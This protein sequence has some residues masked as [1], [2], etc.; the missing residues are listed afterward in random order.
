VEHDALILALR[1]VRR[2]RGLSQRDVGVLMGRR[3]YAN[4]HDWE[5]GRTVPT[6]V[7]FLEWADVLGF[8]VTLTSR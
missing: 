4:V 3:S 6:L 8:D 1:A 7:N 5:S 2:A